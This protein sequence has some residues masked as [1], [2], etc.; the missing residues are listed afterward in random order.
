[1]QSVTK[2][3]PAISDMYPEG[4]HKQLIIK[5]DDVETED[6]VRYFQQ[7]IDF[8]KGGL[9]DGGHV[10]VHCIAGMSRSPTVSILFICFLFTLLFLICS[11]NRQIL[12]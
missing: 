2:E 10:L 4:D 6:L 3:A 8:I 11:L 12:N 9:K 7:S 1:M 5:A